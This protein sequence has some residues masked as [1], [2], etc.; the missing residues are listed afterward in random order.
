MLIS[1][2]MELGILPTDLKRAP[3]TIREAVA[4]FFVDVKAGK[5]I[6]AG[7]IDVWHEEKRREVAKLI[8]LTA[9][10]YGA[11]DGK[12]CYTISDKGE[13]ES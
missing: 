9:T 1:K 7:R 11:R 8:T 4:T 3:L 13:A 6:T 5:G 2:C 12:P 10:G